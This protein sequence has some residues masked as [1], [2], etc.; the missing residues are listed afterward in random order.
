MDI[1]TKRNKWILTILLVVSLFAFFG[2]GSSKVEA[3]TVE[4]TYTQDFSFLNS[5]NATYATSRTYTD[6]NGFAWSILARIELGAP[7]LGNA[8]D[9]SFVQVVAT[10]GVS[11]LSFDVVRFSTNTNPRSGEVFVNDQ[12]VGT[13]TVDTTSNV[14][15]NINFNDINVEGEVTIKIV[16]TSSGTRGAFYVD[17]VSWSTYTAPEPEPEE[18]FVPTGDLSEL[19]GAYVL[20]G[21]Y[22]FDLSKDTFNLIEF[23]RASQTAFLNPETGEYEIYMNIGSKWYNLAKENPFAPSNALEISETNGGNGYKYYDGV[24]IS[25]FQLITNKTQKLGYST[26]QAAIDAANTGDLIA[27]N[28]DVEIEGTVQINNAITL[29]GNGY[30]LIA[31]QDFGT[32]NSNKHSINIFANNVTINDLVIEAANFTF[33]VQAYGSQT[34]ALND[35]TIKDSKG[36][37]LTING[38]SVVATNFVTSGS[39]WG[40]VNIDSRVSTPSAFTLVSGTLNEALQIWSEEAEATISAP[41]FSEYVYENGIREFKLISVTP[42]IS[43]IREGVTYVYSSVHQAVAGAQSGEE[44]LLQ[45][46]TYELDSHLVI[47]K[48]VTIKGIGS[49]I[50]EASDAFAFTSNANKNLILIDTVTGLVKL[51][52]ITVQNS[53]RTGINVYRSNNVELVDVTIKDNA[54]AGLIVNGST[55][56]ATNLYTSGNTW[57]AVN[58]DQ[59]GG[60]TQIPVFTLLGDSQLTEENQIWAEKAVAVIIAEGFDEYVFESG[61]RRFST[62]ALTANVYFERDNKTFLFDTIQAG[63]DAASANTTVYVNEG[64]YIVPS[65]V[66]IN[67]ENLTLQAIGEVV[68]QYSSDIEAPSP[69]NVTG[70]SVLKDLGTVTVNG[71]TVKGFESGI[72][73]SMGNA[74]GT[75]FIVEYNTVYPG[76]KNDAP[77]M[78]N[79]IQVSGDNSVVRYNT[80][81][82]APL[83]TDWSG[84]AIQVVNASHVLVEHNTITD[85]LYDIGISVMNWAYLPGMTDITIRNNTITNAIDGVRISGNVFERMISNVIIENNIITGPQTAPEQW[86]K[87]IDMQTVTVDQVQIVNNTF[88]FNNSINIEVRISTLVIASNVVLEK[89]SEKTAIVNQ[90]SELRFL[91]SSSYTGDIDQIRFGHNIYHTAQISVYRSVTIDA[92]GF[93]LTATQNFG[94]VNGHKHSM[95]IF[96][97]DVEIKNLIID[98]AVNTYGVQAY[99]SVDTELINVTINNSKGAALTINGASVVAT[100]FVTSGSAWGAVNID[101]RVSTPSAF[102]LVSGTLNEA[103]QIWSEEAEAIITTDSYNEFI[104]ENGVRLFTN[105]IYLPEISIIR[106]EVTYVF[107]TIQGAIQNAIAGEEILV[108]AGIYL[109]PSKVWITKDLT[110]TGETGTIFQNAGNDILG[111]QPNIELNISGV[112]FEGTSHVGIDMAAGAIL[113]AD[114]LEFSGLTTGIYVNPNHTISVTNSHF[115]NLVASIG[116]DTKAE[117]FT[118]VNNTFV[119][120]GEVLGFTANNDTE[121]NFNALAAYIVGNNNDVELDQIKAYGNFVIAINLTTGVGYTTIQAAMD[122]ALFGHTIKVEPGTYVDEEIG[123]N[124]HVQFDTNGIKLT[125]DKE[126]PAVLI[127]NAATYYPIFEVFASDI[128]IENF[129]LERNNATSGGQAIAIRNSNTLV[130]SVTIRGTSTAAPAITIDHGIPGSYALDVENIEVR[131]VHISGAFAYGFLVRNSANSNSTG[132]MNDVRI[133]DNNITGTNYGLVVW[134]G[135]ANPAGNPIIGNLTITGN[136]FYNTGLLNVWNVNNLS[137]V[138]YQAVIANNT[139]EDEQVLYEQ[140]QLRDFSEVNIINIDKQTGH[141]SIQSAVN[142]ASSGEEILVKAGTYVISSK[143]WITKDLT[144]TGEAGTIFQ[145]AGNDILGIQPNI[146]LNIS[147]VRFEG[148]SHVGIDMAA[149]AILNADNLEFSGL[150][151]GIYVNPNHTISV[152]NSHFENLVASIGTDTKAENFTIVN[153]TFVNVGEVLGF[154]ANNDTEIN[155]NAL[156]AYIVGNNNDVELDQIKAYGNFVIAINLTTGVGYTTIQA[157]INAAQTSDTITVEPGVYELTQQL[158]VNKSITLKGIG[159]VTLTTAVNFNEGTLNADKH[160]V[161]I[162]GVD[163]AVFENFTVQNSRRTGLNVFESTDVVLKDVILKDNVGAGLGITN[164]EV[165]AINLSTSGNGWAGVNVDNGSIPGSNAPATVFTLESGSIDMIYSNSGNVTVNVPVGYFTY[166]YFGVPNLKHV[167]VEEAQTLTGVAVIEVTKFE[168]NLYATFQLAYQAAVEGSEILVTAGTYTFTS[169]ID[170]TKSVSIQGEEGV[171]FTSTGPTIFV[172]QSGKTLEVNQVEFSG[173]NGY[174]I[175]LAANST[176]IITNSIFSTTY[177]IYVNTGGNLTVTDSM[178][179]VT[180][181]VGIGTDTKA[182]TLNITGNTFKEGLYETVGFTAIRDIESNFLAFEQALIAN[183]TNVTEDNVNSYGVF[184]KDYAMVVALIGMVDELE[185]TTASYATYQLVVE[186]YDLSV[187]STLLE[188]SQAYDAIKAAQLQLVEATVFNLTNSNRYASIQVAVNEAAEYDVIQVVEGTYDGFVVRTS[189]ITI[190]AVGEVFV[191]PNYFA[192]GT[193]GQTVAIVV[194]GATNVTLKGMQIVGNNEYAGIAGVNGAIFTVD[195]MHFENLVRGIYANGNNTSTGFITNLTITNSTFE[196]L[197]VGIGGTENTVLSATNNVFE[198]ERSGSEGFGLGTGVVMSQTLH[199]LLKA[200]TFVLTDDNYAL[201][202][203]R[204]AAPDRYGKTLFLSSASIFNQLIDATFF[205]EVHFTS[206]VSTIYVTRAVDIDFGNYAVNRIYITTTETGTMNMYG[207]QFVNALLQIDSPNLVVNNYIAVF[208]DLNVIAGTFNDFS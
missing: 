70:I 151:T 140:N 174:A 46:G 155:F 126:N 121:I 68:I 76:Y 160:L 143:V 125:T 149:G 109:F 124:N 113:N 89:D 169:R 208:G 18:P 172:V 119:N 6:S 96:A 52:N 191:S 176:A 182:S 24:H 138:D 102:T 88:D 71:F 15:Q 85:S 115:E 92:L 56:T 77:Y 171:I 133:I 198:L 112:R 87:G 100:N 147:G 29:D 94:E 105:R 101:S 181:A 207:D 117:N 35:V 192:A 108:K 57:G 47:N 127:N 135:T 37:A 39:A 185:Y 91:L 153:N 51:E 134:F 179:D 48:P 129:I 165:T 158:R 13:F 74:S 33:G 44:I 187:S 38:A 175:E 60:I 80:V 65:G 204:T 2:F 197:L 180:G 123:V 201:I 67:K 83:S 54:A 99:G 146:E 95:I 152:T 27:L 154:T 28:G 156:A 162:I 148:T 5:A 11:S 122:N 199:G 86:V 206:S 205:T 200:N 55:V 178:F 167:W 157:A 90:E 150:T 163:G 25:E 159:E 164:S 20:V 9:G 61:L 104:F 3:S 144:I 141:S 118:I 98:A 168:Y 84:T 81:Y 128:I 8:A 40:A 53:L 10:G 75:A 64:V 22:L 177:G 59:G 145:N 14:N 19:E 193:L 62:V 66:V 183:N 132:T 78:R 103:L 16:T 170:V 116:T 190:E 194:D 106:G 26:L 42:D 41:G 69:Y 34:T 93:A 97:D 63:I 79:G 195:Q 50:L 49:V 45:S 30:N 173:G 21:D 161:G 189:N 120:V 136:E 130:D 32:N 114:N 36:A 186:S 31:T 203:Y 7:V 82:G 137:N 139:F 111:I 107:A 1:Y 184:S 202:D 4:T 110:I 188:T 17:N 43:I 58:V 12:S 196:N 131:N 72:V 23:L 73:Q 142:A 166:N